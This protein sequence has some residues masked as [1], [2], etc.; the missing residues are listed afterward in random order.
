M[1]ENSGE[2]SG[3]AC[4]VRIESER[5]FK[6]NGKTEKDTRL[7]ISSLQADA[8]LINVSVRSHWSVENSLHWVL[9]VGFNEDH[10]RKR[11]GFAAQNYSLLNRIALN[12]LKNERTAK[13]GVRG[14][15][16]KAGWN[17]RYLMQLIKN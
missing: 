14:K 1:I 9:D 3:L 16:L 17:N 7:Y 2:W 12:L 10:S 5:Y 4:V 15:R 13:V 6:S 11:S 8:K